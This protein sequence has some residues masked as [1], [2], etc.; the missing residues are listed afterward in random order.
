MHK[1]RSG[2]RAYRIIKE[3]GSGLESRTNR[4][5]IG[6]RGRC[7]RWCLGAVFADHRAPFA[8]RGVVAADRGSFSRRRRLNNRAEV[9]EKTWLH[10]KGQVAVDLH[11]RRA[12]RRRKVL[13]VTN[14]PKFGW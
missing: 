10:E 6:G 4:A 1:K 5:C 3:R 2:G 8:R 9:H 11:G 13:A 14:F 12:R 7:C